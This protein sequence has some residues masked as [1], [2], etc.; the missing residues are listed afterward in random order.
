[1]EIHG[2]FK[3]NPVKLIM[4]KH[5]LG[6][7]REVQKYIDNECIKLMSPY[8]PF[9]TG[10]LEKSAIRNTVIGSGR[11]TQNTPYARYL[12][13]GEVYG[14]NLPIRNGKISFN[15]EDG[16]IEKWVSPKKKY[17]TGRDIKYNKSGHP[18]AG[19]LWFERMKSDH[20]DDILRGARK[21]AGGR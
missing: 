3:I 14:P 16:P 13:Y 17:P 2:S 10:N 15:P 18:L 4:N 6:D 20:T 11:I 21:I 7:M 1:M 19:K 8:T 9:L 12:Y 5:G